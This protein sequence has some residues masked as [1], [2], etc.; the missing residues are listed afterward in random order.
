MRRSL[1][2]CLLVAAAALF[3]AGCHQ[4][5]KPSKK[6]GSPPT[7]QAKE[8]VREGNR[9]P[10]IVGEDADGKSFKLSD[11]RGKVVLLDFWF[12]R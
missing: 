5:G 2:F 1:Q 12:E 11:Y 9:A 3:A 10:E 8:G 6:L 7:G 4:A